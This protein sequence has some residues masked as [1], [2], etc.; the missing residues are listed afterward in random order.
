MGQPDSRFRHGG[1]ARPFIPVN[2]AVRLRRSPKA[3]CSATSAV[4]S[5]GPLRAARSVCS[6]RQRRRRVSRRN[7]RNA[8]DLQPKLL[9]VL[10]QAREVT[11]VGA[12]RPVKIDVQV[13][14]A[15]IRNLEKEVVD[16]R[17]REDL[18]YR[19][20]MV[21]LRVPALRQRPED[22][23]E[24]IEFFSDAS[25]AVTV[26]RRG[27]PIARPCSGFANIT[28]RA[29]SGNWCKSSSNRTCWIVCRLCPSLSAARREQSL[30]LPFLNLERLRN[31]SIRQAL[32]VTRGH[33]GLRGQAVGRASQYADPPAKPLRGIADHSRGHGRG[34]RL[35]LGLNLGGPIESL[36]GWPL[37]GDDRDEQAGSGR[38]FRD[39]RIRGIVGQQSGDALLEQFQF[40]Q[41]LI[42]PRFDL[43][44]RIR[45]RLLFRSRHGRA[46]WP[47]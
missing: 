17:F 32:R 20:N 10:Q 12:L 39:G 26:A 38:F 16:G 33:K 47:G 6:V 30:T 42:L 14:A 43:A 3:N 28:G 34:V 37:L 31:E 22:I 13:I 19:L 23:P 5:P 41:D 44:D 15:M 25:P 35:C 11:P 9:R 2:C 27:A 8:A 4:P 21:E 36:V 24:L 29:I 46:S 45:G 7:R 18:Y 40:A 1:A